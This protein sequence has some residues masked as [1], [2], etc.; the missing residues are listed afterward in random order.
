[1][2]LTNLVVS[3]IVLQTPVDR[4]PLGCY[5]NFE[6][7]IDPRPADN[8]AISPP[9]L[10][11][12]MPFLFGVRLTSS[13]TYEST[14]SRELGTNVIT[15][16]IR[17]TAAFIDFATPPS[18]C[19]AVPMDALPVGQY[20]VRFV[21]FV[22]ISPSFPYTLAGDYEDF[23]RFSV[24]PGAMRVDTMASKSVIGLS[25]LIASCGFFVL[26]KR[27]RARASR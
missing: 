5:V 12:S 13:R 19:V 17:E 9:A 15:V 1:M 8:Y 2:K 14:V 16:Q 26:R 21:F 6:Q 4:R 27:L 25:L 10:T 3:V 24:V 7:P 18:G 23:S 20:S 11:D 22:R